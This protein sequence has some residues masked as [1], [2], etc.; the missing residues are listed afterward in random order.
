[1]IVI[2]VMSN[3]GIGLVSRHVT[4]AIIAAFTVSR[5]H[6]VAERVEKLVGAW[7]RDR[8]RL[9]V[10]EELQAAGI[11]A[12]PVA[13]FGDLHDDPQLAHREHFVSLEHTVVGECLYERNGFR[14]SGAPSSY[15]AATPALG[16]HTDAV[17]GE[18]LGIGKAE[19]E[20]LGESGALD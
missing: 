7:T 10:A 19:R 4:P 14:L 17:L 6:E 9:D 5:M 18:I 16:P 3:T 20:Q 2:A 1:M 8:T 11:E 12:V 15:P 13:D